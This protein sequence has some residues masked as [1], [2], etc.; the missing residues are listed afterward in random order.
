MDVA[1]VGFEVFVDVGVSIVG[2]WEWLLFVVC[3]G[4]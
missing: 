1:E 3:E 4:E 2:V